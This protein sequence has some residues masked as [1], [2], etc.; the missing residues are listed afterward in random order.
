MAVYL[1]K[2]RLSPKKHWGR[3]AAEGSSTTR[4][5]PNCG[6]QAVPY[7]LQRDRIAYKCKKCGAINTYT[8]MPGGDIP[9]K[10]QKRTK[11]LGA[12]TVRDRSKGKEEKVVA[13]RQK[14]Q[15]DSTNEEAVHNNIKSIRESMKDQKVISFKYIDAHGNETARNVEPYKLTVDKKGDIIL[16]GFCLEGNGIRTFKIKRTADCCKTEYKFKP[17]FSIED[18]LSDD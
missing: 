11:K 15:E 17:Q 8:Q 14:H 7:E 5:C 12:V 16:Y 9:N 3:K 18:N 1:S 4:T 13:T 6:E 2:K 10:K